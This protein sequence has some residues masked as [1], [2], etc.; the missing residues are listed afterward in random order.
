[1]LDISVSFLRYGDR[2]FIHL[3]V[4]KNCTALTVIGI[5][6]MHNFEQSI[7]QEPKI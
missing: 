7:K 6:N 2:C 4:L 5:S 1:M 3:P